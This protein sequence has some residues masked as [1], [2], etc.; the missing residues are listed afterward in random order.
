MISLA[1]TATVA[2]LDVL[3]AVE[4]GAL[5]AAGAAAA[6]DAVA[7]VESGAVAGVVVVAASDAKQLNEL[8]S[9]GL[10]GATAGSDAAIFV[11]SASVLG[12]WLASGVNLLPSFSLM[13][14]WAV[15]LVLPPPPA[16]GARSSNP[17]PP[18][19]TGAS[20]S[21]APHAL[22]N[23]ASRHSPRP[24]AGHTNESGA[25]APQGHVTSQ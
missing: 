22:A 2:A 18:P 8:A 10:L 15:R 16:A 11:D 20:G 19:P 12:E 6:L 13:V 21:S 23:G 4:S 5:S 9:A 25:N 7:R 3:A 24:V 1:P 17:P 14:G